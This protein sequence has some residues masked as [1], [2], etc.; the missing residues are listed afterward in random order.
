MK[1]FKPKKSLGQNFLIN[2]K[3]LP[4][5]IKAAEIKK[6]DTIIEIGPGH[7]ILTKALLDAQAKVFAIEKDFA[8][9]EK[10]R[11]A[12]GFHKNL[13]IIH[14][15]ALFFDP[16]MLS[17]YKVVA[18]MPF[19]IASSIIR[20]FL[21]SPHPPE[22]MVVMIQKEVAQKIVAKPGDSSRGIL[23]LAVELY[24]DA[25]IV[26]E[27]SKSSFRP[28]PKVDAAVIKIQPYFNHKL[29]TRYGGKEVKSELF[30]R[31]VRAGFSAKRRQI[32]NSLAATLRLDKNTVSDILKKSQIDPRLRAEDLTLEQWIR[33]TKNLN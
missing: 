31:I 26:A 23:T 18:N 4:T 29:H 7:G 8:L 12:L 20:K 32:H 27:V 28:V 17:K 3:I 16:S 1:M 33:L 21:E 6:D 5:I 10:L 2:D 25:E 13:K 24:A 19:N 22:L 14:Q 15:D 11:Q 30:F 9:V